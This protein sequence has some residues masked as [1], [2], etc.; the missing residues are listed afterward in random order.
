MAKPDQRSTPAEH[1]QFYFE[2]LTKECGF[3]S[4][5]A[6]DFFAMTLKVSATF[7]EVPA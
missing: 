1:R 3:S 5:D 7:Y 2:M 4:N 6:T